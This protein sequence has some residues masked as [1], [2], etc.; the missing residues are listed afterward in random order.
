MLFSYRCERC[1]GFSK[2]KCTLSSSR[3]FRRSS[4]STTHNQTSSCIQTLDTGCF[5]R[6]LSSIALTTSAFWEHNHILYAV[7]YYWLHRLRYRPIYRPARIGSPWLRLRKREGWT[8]CWE[9]SSWFSKRSWK[10]WLVERKNS[11]CENLDCP[12]LMCSVHVCFWLWF[13]SESWAVLFLTVF[14]II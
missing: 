7:S 5:W 3:N 14:Q 4:F 6:R 13:L 12:S 1:P 2:S 8:G 10:S 9:T 11:N